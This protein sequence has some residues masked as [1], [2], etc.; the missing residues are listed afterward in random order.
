VSDQELTR[1]SGFLDRVQP[2]DVV[3]ADRGFFIEDELALRGASLAIPAF[4][5]GKSQLSQFEVEKSRQLA[6]IRIHVERVIGM[7]KNRDDDRG[8]ATVDKLLLVCAVLT[9]LGEPIV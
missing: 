1:S 7:L 3:L 6:R 5:K 4:T 9:N 8:I 2:G